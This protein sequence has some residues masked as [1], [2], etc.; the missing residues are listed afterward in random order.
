MKRILTTTCATLCAFVAT[1]EMSAPTRLIIDETSSLHW[2][3]YMAGASGIKLEWP[4]GAA[5][6]K[7]TI[8]GKGGTTVHLFDSSASSFVP[9]LPA[10][11]SDEDVWDMTLEFYAAA[12]ATGA[13]M[14]GETLSA[15]GIGIV[16]GANSDALELRSTPTSSRA[17][18]KVVGKTAVLPVPDGTTSLELDGVAVAV[19]ATP[20]WH[21]WKPS[22]ADRDYAWGA[23]GDD[24]AY[25]AT[26]RRSNPGFLCVFK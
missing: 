6:A 8:S 3:T 11:A 9:T 13:A 21:L 20:G 22:A 7:L 1:A 19:A 26:L 15:T 4:E 24:F 10:M 23:V 17:W 5:S 16:R 25:A 12:G 14:D 18:R 2:R